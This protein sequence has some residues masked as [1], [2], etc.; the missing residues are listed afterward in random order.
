MV[1]RTST[2]YSTPRPRPP[3]PDKLND[4]VGECGNSLYQPILDRYIAGGEVA[5]SEVRPVWR[6]PTQPMCSVSGFYEILF[7][8]V[9]RINQRL[10]APRR[11]RMLAGGPPIDWVKVR[12]KSEVMLDRDASIASVMQEGSSIVLSKN[13]K[14]SNC[15]SWI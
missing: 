1:I 8:L 4:V 13:R 5:I 12:N 9:R 7:P 15:G 11:L 6:N 14:E 2:T 10:P 3:F